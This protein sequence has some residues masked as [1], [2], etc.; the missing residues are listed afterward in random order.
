MKVY[1]KSRGRISA[2]N[3]RQRL[4]TLESAAFFPPGSRLDGLYSPG[5][6]AL[7]SEI[8]STSAINSGFVNLHRF[9][10]LYRSSIT[11]SRASCETSVCVHV[12]ELEF[13]G[14]NNMIFTR[15]MSLHLNRWQHD[16]ASHRIWADD[17]SEIKQKR[18]SQNWD[19]MSTSKMSIK[20]N[21]WLQS[22][23]TLQKYLVWLSFLISRGKS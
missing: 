22:L 13:S 5:S 12:G 10:L 11:L 8:E 14:W 23:F 4:I 18:S 15:Q 1:C 9:Y 19:T 20:S 21:S 17:A 2:V 16:E 7:L 3:V 6:S